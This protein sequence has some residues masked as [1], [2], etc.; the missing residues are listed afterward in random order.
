MSK[1][2]EPDRHR[3]CRLRIALS[4]PSRRRRL[5]SEAQG[6]GRGSPRPSTIIRNASSGST[7]ARC[8]ATDR[9]LRKRNRN[10]PERWMVRFIIGIDGGGDESRASRSPACAARPASSASPAAVMRLGV[11]SRG[12][13]A[14]VGY[15]FRI[16]VAAAETQI[17]ANRCRLTAPTGRRGTRTFVTSA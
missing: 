6:R 13:L 11:S 9:G 15:P 14:V 1:N 12:G 16:A 5:R 8:P 10:S 7:S 3:P 2:K 4:P 17:R